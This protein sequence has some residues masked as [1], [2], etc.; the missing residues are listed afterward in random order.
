MATTTTRGMVGDDKR[1]RRDLGPIG[2]LFMAVGSIIGSGWLFATQ[3]AA[4]TAG[5]ASVFAWLIGAVMFILI[6]LTYAELGTMFPHAGGVARFPHYSHGSF[7]SFSMGWITWLAAASVAPIEVEAA[8]QYA[9]NYLPWLEDIRG[10]V[11]VLT[12]AGYGVSAGLMAVFVLINYFG[13]RWFARVN[14][15]VVW[16]KLFIIILVIVIFLVV[17][18][19]GAHFNLPS[20]GGFAPYGSHG[21]FSAVA[22]AGIAFAFFGFRQGVE[23]AGETKNPGRNVPLT[24]VG[25]VVITGII[26]IALQVA[27]IGAA[28]T[29]AITAQGWAKV[30]ENFTSGTSVL[31]QFG[32]LAAIATVLGLGWLAVLLYID[33][34]I[35]PADTGLIYTGVTAR[36]SYAMGRNRNAPQGLAKVNEHGVPWVSLILAFIVGLI[37]FLPFPGWQKLVGFVT[38]STVLSFGA[39]PIVLLAM[40][41]QLPAYER[42]FRLA[43][44]WVIAFLAMWSS[45]LIV[46]WTGWEID[47][48]LFVAILI[49]FVLLGI[50]QTVSRGSTPPLDFRHG[51][52][53]LPWF[54]GLAIISYL[55]SYPEPFAGNQGI[56]GFN[57]GI[58]A[59][60]L[61][62][63]L[64]VWL[65]YTCRLPAER[66]QAEIGGSTRPAQGPADAAGEES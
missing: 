23:M 11:P 48:K 29:K 31:A 37:F 62:S 46:Y 65:G 35:S 58:L 50:N 55:G 66:V 61:L 56:I 13:V 17:G 28:P 41:K 33:A 5:P 9:T 18:F 16:W 52:W 64:V 40:R 10:G 27:F 54:A 30:G 20:A 57:L 51:W 53:V 12:S 60:F 47:W 43:A 42:P 63:V 26:Y 1:I 22:T 15:T 34:V 7:A 36:L 6:G 3:S 39:G 8:V 38:S 44:G 59:T 25:S 19:H 14:T 32:P 4:E 45:N 49:G 24:V 2:L 21:V